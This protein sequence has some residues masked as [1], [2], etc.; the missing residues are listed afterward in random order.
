VK[1]HFNFYFKDISIF[2]DVSRLIYFY[3]DKQPIYNPEDC[4]SMRL[5]MNTMITLFF[6]I[7]DVEPST[8]NTDIIMEDIINDN[9]SMDSDIITKKPITN[10]RARGRGQLNDD[11]GLRKDVLTKNLKKPSHSSDDDDDSNEE[12]EDNSDDEDHVSQDDEEEEEEDEEEEEEERR[13]RRVAYRRAAKVKKT[14][15]NKKVASTPPKMATVAS[16]LEKEASIEPENQKTYNFF[17][18]NGYYCFFRL[19]QL[20]YDR[21]SKMKS[22]DTEFRKD[23]EKLK[24][25]QKEAQ[26]LGITPKRF[27]SLK[28][29]TKRGY[30]NLLLSLIDKLFQQDIDQQTFEESIRYIFGTE[31]YIMFTIDKLVL[32]LVRHIHIIIADTQSQELYDLFKREHV[33][34]AV[35]QGDVITYRTR[36]AGIIDSNENTYHISFVSCI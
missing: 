31:A 29:D 27:R 30:Y 8:T 16:L 17:G 34:E 12:S 13:P 2:K 26:D 3:L 28:L 25:A 36:V 5:F 9:E 15:K 1:P 33:S 10:R 19:Y 14:V 22:L 6:D 11:D 23:P 20:L 18:N 24:K 7:T 35:E 4:E 32:S 21:L